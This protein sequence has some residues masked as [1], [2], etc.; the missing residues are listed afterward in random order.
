MVSANNATLPE[1]VKQVED[2][3][4]KHGLDVGLVVSRYSFSFV[5]G[6]LRSKLVV[7]TGLLNAITDVELAAL[8]EHEVAHHVRRDNLFKWILTICRYLSPAFP[9]TGLLYRWWSEQ[10]ERVCDEV[11]A[12]QTH[13]PVEVAGALVRL[14]RLTLNGQPRRLRSTGAGFLGEQGEGFERRVLRVLSLVDQAEINE[15]LTL[16]R[17]WVRDAALIGVGFAL[18]LMGLFTVSPLAIHRIIEAILRI[19]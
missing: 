8:L 5:W 18:S 2:A 17:S 11:A 4:Q 14:R 13:A 10:V 9:L 16:S 3:C 19:F 7:S 1:R 12:Q 6:Y 15:G